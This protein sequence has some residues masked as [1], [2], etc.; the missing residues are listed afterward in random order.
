MHCWLNLTAAGDE[1]D[2]GHESNEGLSVPRCAD[3]WH[4]VYLVAEN[5]SYPKMK[6]L[7]SRSSLEATPPP[8]QDTCMCL[9]AVLMLKF[10]PL[11]EQTPI[12][13]DESHEGHEGKW[14]LQ[15]KRC[16]LLQQRPKVHKLSFV[17]VVV[18][19]HL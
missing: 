3:V 1:S 9:R 4:P 7:K 16:E 19:C 15:V 13:G 11:S 10:A 6:D 17:S 18:H 2:E 14:F 8:Q 5:R 12:A